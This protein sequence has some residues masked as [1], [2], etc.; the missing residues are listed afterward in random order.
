VAEEPG[1]R[2]I[3]LLHRQF[4]TQHEALYAYTTAEAVECINL[5]LAALVPKPAVQL[6]EQPAGRAENARAEERRAYFPETGP[7]PMPVYQRDRLGSGA[8]LPGP[9]VV[10]DEWSTTLIYPG[11][12]LQVDRWGTLIIE[13]IR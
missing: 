2:E 5:R 1:G 8:M 9:A 13:E 6:P 3:A 4:Q 10:E 7:V 11:Q 12:R